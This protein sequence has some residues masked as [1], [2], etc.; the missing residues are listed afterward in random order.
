MLADPSPGDAAEVQERD[1]PRWR[2]S[3]GLKAGR[4]A[5]T[6]ERQPGNFKDREPVALCRQAEYEIETEGSFALLT[7]RS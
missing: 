2:R 7:A 5:W 3:C 6:L 1:A 4:R